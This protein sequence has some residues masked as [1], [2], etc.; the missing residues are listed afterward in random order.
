MSAQSASAIVD[1]SKIP[2]SLAWSLHLSRGMLR[3]FTSQRTFNVLF[4][5]QIVLALIT[6]IVVL[7]LS[8]CGGDFAVEAESP[9]RYDLS[10]P[11]TYEGCAEDA[12]YAASWEAFYGRLHRC[13]IDF[14]LCIAVRSSP[15][16]C[17][18]GCEPAY[19]SGS[20]CV[21]ECEEHRKGVE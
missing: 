2:L 5:T 15:V 16:S 8:G 9:Q 11:V 10:C 1:T 21:D 18:K 12:R 7:G 13:A 19:T 20:D 17:H 4:F 6:L 14:G 3:S